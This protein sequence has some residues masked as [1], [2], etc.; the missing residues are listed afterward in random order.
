MDE[1]MRRAPVF[2]AI[3]AVSVGIGVVMDFARINA[4]SAMYWSAVINGV[5]APFLLVGILIAASDNTLMKGQP[6]SRL[7][8]V[9]VGITVVVMFA[10]AIGMFVF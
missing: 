7:G 8:R 9:T 1:P 10:A 5:L 6:S 4:V 3:F 2:Y